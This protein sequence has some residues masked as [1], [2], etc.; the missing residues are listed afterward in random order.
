MISISV[1]CQLLMQYL[2]NIGTVYESHGMWEMCGYYLVMGKKSPVEDS[3][4]AQASLR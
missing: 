2:Q 1:Q 4:E 3:D